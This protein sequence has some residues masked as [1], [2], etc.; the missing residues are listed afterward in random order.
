L[1]TGFSSAPPIDAV[2]PDE[3]TL[4]TAR[5]PYTIVVT[6]RVSLSASTPV[7]IRVSSTVPWYRVRAG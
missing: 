6:R 7:A 4:K 1:G 3:S 5:S 2:M